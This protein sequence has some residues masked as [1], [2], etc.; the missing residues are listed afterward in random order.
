MA[1]DGFRR[2]SMPK[3]QVV[4][5]SGLKGSGVT[6]ILNLLA[7]ICSGKPISSTHVHLAR[8]LTSGMPFLKQAAGKLGHSLSVSPQAVSERDPGLG[9]HC[10]AVEWGNPSSSSRTRYHEYYLIN[11]GSLVQS[12]TQPGGTTQ[13]SDQ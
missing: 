7:A 11:L 8:V 9:F 13:L 2:D 5:A 1:G 10:I 4:E 3:L 6:E 12:L